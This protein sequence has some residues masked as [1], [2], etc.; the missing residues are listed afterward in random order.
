MSKLNADIL[1]LIFKKLQNDKKTL[2]S[3]LSVNKTWCEIIIPILWNNPWKYFNGDDDTNEK[4]L[5]DKI[6]SYLSEES[7]N[8]LKNKGI[9]LSTN[10]YK[11]PLFD[12]ISFC[13]HLN[14][15][16]I[17]RII[18]NSGKKI[19]L[20]EIIHLFI[21]ENTK[22]THLHIPQQFNYQIHLI[23]G[24]ERCFSEIE[25]LSCN[26]SIND[27]VLDG[28]IE[29]CKSIR[30]LELYIN[31]VNNNYKISKLIENPKKLL[32]VRLLC[33]YALYLNHDEPFCKII[34]DSL[35]KHSNAIQYFKI[36]KQPTTG[37][38]S[39]FI[40]LKILELN[41]NYHKLKWDCL[42]IVSLPFLQILKTIYIPIKPLIS[43]IENTGGYLNEISVN[44]IPHND[45]DNKGIIHAIYTKCPK[46]KY[47]KLEFKNSNILEL[48]K[49]LI[50]CQHLNGLF[51]VRTDF[52]WNNLFEIL[53]KSSPNSLFKFKFHVFRN[54][55]HDSLKL[56]FDNWKGKHP[57]LLQFSQKSLEQYSDLIEEYKAEGVVKIFDY[58]LYNEDF[59]WI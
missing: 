49:L 53:S 47:L 59:D 51:F 25:F 50:K 24:A 21:N 35:I 23:P 55:D 37:I 4:M 27:N 15:N 26:T 3:C 17:K 30:E 5:L 28:L 11:R 36:T 44:I 38:L 52:D 33:N 18:I 19:I 58:N 9:K 1:Y 43:L 16:A 46:L 40:N 10:L 22:F 8:N 12:Y 54:V 6:I 45:I 31:I 39:R 57:L 41:G 7:R 20:N 2:Y 14:L 42:E 32:N 48:E 34:E 56:F 29:M 13:R